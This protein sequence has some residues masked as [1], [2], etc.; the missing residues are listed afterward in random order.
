MTA[1][2]AAMSEQT[3]TVVG[4][5][6][7][8]F[9][10]AVSLDGFI[11]DTDGSLEWLFAAAAGP[12]PI[13]TCFPRTPALWWRGRRRTSGYSRRRICWRAPS[14]GESSMATHPR[15]SS[16]RARCRFLA[17]QFFDAGALDEIAVSVAPVTLGAGAPLLPRRIEAE[18]LSLRSAHAAGPFAR[19]VYDIVPP[20]LSFT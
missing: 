7:I 19:L 3:P 11:A 17:G 13:Q 20:T 6:R 15:S 14:A 9:D 1:L 18:H 12:T 10:T 2:E 4:M 8:I 5:G 16:P